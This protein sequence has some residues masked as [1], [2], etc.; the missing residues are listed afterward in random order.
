MVH[1]SNPQ[2]A[3]AVGIDFLRFRNCGGYSGD[4]ALLVCLI[5]CVAN[6]KPHCSISAGGQV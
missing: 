5:N 4:V 1:C 6:Q 3:A 2:A